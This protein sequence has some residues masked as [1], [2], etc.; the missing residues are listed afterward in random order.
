MT[1]HLKDKKI[2]IQQRTTI[3]DP[4]GFQTTVW[5]DVPGCS[6]I[7]AYYRQA[8]GSEFYT[9][10]STENKVEAIFEINYHAGLSTDMYVLFRG[11]YYGITR[12]DDYEGYKDTLRL[13][14][15]RWEA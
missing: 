13:E 9:A 6:N 14:A 10:A 1:V 8:S 2:S 5:A 12:I 3:T 4:D 15:Y 11:Q 7:W